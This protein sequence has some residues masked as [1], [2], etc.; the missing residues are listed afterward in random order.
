MFVCKYVVNSIWILVMGFSKQTPN[1]KHQ[2]QWFFKFQLRYADMH[3]SIWIL[4]VGLVMGL[5][6]GH[7]NTK[8]G[9]IYSL[10]QFLFASYITACH[11]HQWLEIKFFTLFLPFSRARKIDS[12]ALLVQK[13]NMKNNMNNAM[14]HN[15]QQLWWCEAFVKYNTIGRVYECMFPPC[16]TLMKILIWNFENAIHYDVHWNLSCAILWVWK[17]IYQSKS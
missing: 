9:S 12:K 11:R 16:R 10:Q 6:L 7:W 14:S 3:I 2:G 5:I 15:S 1:T 17:H 8:I 13:E 4:V